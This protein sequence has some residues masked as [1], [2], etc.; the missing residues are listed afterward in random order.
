MKLNEFIHFNHRCPVCD[1]DLTLYL[2]M[3]DSVCFRAKKQKQNVYHFEPFKCMN[4]SISERDYIDLYDFG[5]DFE[6]KFSSSQM[7]A[8]AKRSQL[9]FF[10]MCDEHGFEDDNNKTDYTINVYQGCYYRS[11]PFLEYQKTSKKA[12]V[13]KAIDPD[14]EALVNQEEVFSFSREVNGIEKVYMLNLDSHN[15][16]TIFM[17]YTADEDQRKDK[18][19]SPNVFEKEIPNLT[20]RPNFS[21]NNRE[22]LLDRFDSWIIMS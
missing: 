19:Y 3:K 6:T 7:A 8:E 1:N 17:H 22:R 20:T 12:W 15:K 5:K 11:T 10:Y 14:Q 2:Q 18:D 9:Y 21:A 13:L 16:K 4:K